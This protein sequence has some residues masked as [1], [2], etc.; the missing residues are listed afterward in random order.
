MVSKLRLELR[1]DPQGHSLRVKPKGDSSILSTE[2]AEI[3]RVGTGSFTWG[4]TGTSIYG[5][6]IENSPIQR[7]GSVN[8]SEKLDESKDFQR[9]TMQD[10]KT[11]VQHPGWH[12]PPRS[13]S[14]KRH[15]SPVYPRYPVESS[16]GTKVPSVLLKSGNLK[17]FVGLSVP[18]ALY[19]SVPRCL[20]T[21]LD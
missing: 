5:G 16:K 9:H 14:W 18:P 7:S 19:P 10:T 4:F 21:R 11:F 1:R 20:Q 13:C 12:G 2:F 8:P 17:L 6:Y 3:P 15:D